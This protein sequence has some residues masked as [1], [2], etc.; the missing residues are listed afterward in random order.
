M[1]AYCECLYFCRQISTTSR[2]LVQGSPTVC[3]CVCVCVCVSYKTQHRCSL[4]PIWTVPPQKK[5]NIY[6]HT[7][8]RV[9]YKERSYNERMLQRTV[10]INKI[11]MLHRT[12]MLKRKRRNTIGRRS[13][14]VCIMFHAFPLW[15]ETLSLSLLSFTRFSYQFSSIICAFGSENI[16]LLIIVL[17][18]LSHEPVK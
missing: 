5:E 6:V 1:F 14:R 17:Y 2:S 18:N 15:L 11:R 9:R 10:F 12:Q 16:F 7:Q 4:S 13:T 3:V 8:S